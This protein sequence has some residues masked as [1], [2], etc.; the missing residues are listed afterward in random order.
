MYSKRY[1][2]SKYWH[3]FNQLGRAIS[4]R[5]VLVATYYR[6]QC[7]LLRVFLSKHHKPL[8]A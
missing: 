4:E 8:P 2:E 5:N 7:Q 1:Y 6:E 3:A